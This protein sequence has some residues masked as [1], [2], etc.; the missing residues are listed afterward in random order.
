[1]SNIL[2][3]DDESSIRDMLRDF[4]TMDRHQIM[5]ADSGEKAIELIQD[6]IFDIA[7]LDLRM[8]K[9]SGMDV[10]EF[11]RETSPDTEVIIITAHGDIDIAI[12]AMRLGAFDFITKPFGLNELGLVM[13]R[14]LKKKEITNNVK[15]L[16]IYGEGKNRFS[17]IIGTAPDMT[18]VLTLIEKVCRYDSSVLITG[19]S[20][21][22][23]D[24]VAK[25]VHANSSRKDKIFIPVSCAALSNSLQESELFG[26]VKGAFTDA[27]DDKKGI[28]EEAHEGTV[29]LDE[30]AEAS[31]STQLKLLRFLEDG[32]IRRVGKNIPTYVDV[33]LITATNKNLAKAIEE[34]KFRLDLYYRINVI[35]IHLPP[36]RDR[37]D[38]IPLLVRHFIKKYTNESGKNYDISQNAFKMLMEYSWPGNVR[39][40]QNVIQ[41]AIT[42][43]NDNIITPECF[44]KSIRSYSN[45]PTVRE[46]SKHTPLY[47]LEKAYILQVLEECAW[48][49]D[50]ASKASGISKPTIYR[51]VKEYN[52]R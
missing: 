2:I 45:Q 24:L 15:A 47:W 39:E 11:I 36:L 20:G 34:G 31:P 25:T 23:K 40:L 13:E 29:F 1:M 33:R 12:K 50:K 5:D 35:E 21:T 42:F 19:E 9:V 41:H 6:N 38:D 44:P 43:S 28:F 52:V 27:I 18:K 17:D 51:K 46:K 10:L 30:I 8:G 48:N 37:K 49:V 7:V 16:Q 14:A 26:H 4:L 22:G 3:V 32:E